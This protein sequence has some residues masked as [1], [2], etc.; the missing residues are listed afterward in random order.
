M[1][2]EPKLDNYRGGTKMKRLTF[3]SMIGILI[4]VFFAEMA[5]SLPWPPVVDVYAI[6]FDYE[7]GYSDD[8]LNIRKNYSTDI[9][10]SEWL[11]SSSRNN[12]FAYIKNQSSRKIKVIF[13]VEEEQ[14]RS[15]AVHTNTSGT[16]VGDVDISF[17]VPWYVGQYWLKTITLGGEE[18]VP[19]SV[20]KRNF[21]WS[22]Y[23]DEISEI[24]LEEPL[25]IGDTGAHTHYTLLAAPQSPMA[26]PWTEVLDYSCVWAS[27][28]SVDSVVAKVVADSIYNGLGDTDGD[29]DYDYPQGRPFFSEGDDWDYREF[30]LT[31]FLN[32]IKNEPDVLINCSDAGNLMNIFSAALGCASESKIIYKNSGSFDTKD[33]DPIGSTASWVTTSWGYH[34]FGW[35]DDKVFDACIKIDRYGTQRV[36]TNMSQSTYDGYLLQQSNYD[37]FTVGTAS[38]KEE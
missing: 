7:S 29:I 35:F 34:Q 17:S 23:L 24:E 9:P 27:G 26:E 1:V 4:S 28:A 30:Y 32:D 38:L 33:I 15:I 21:T 22:W 11:P 5:Y 2:S 19:S 31:A 37:N 13:Y 16:G 8:A 3:L 20:G 25:H 12:P 36:A 6:R 10:L 18:S 14:Y